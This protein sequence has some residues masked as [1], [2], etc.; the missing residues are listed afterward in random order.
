M[1]ESKY[2]APPHS[3]TSRPSLGFPL[4]TALLLLIIFSLSGIFSCCYHWDK[5]RSLRR[6]FSEGTDLEV[7]GDPSY[8]KSKRAY[9]HWKQNQVSDMPA[10]LM[11]GDEVP[12]FIALPCPCQPPRPEKLVDEVQHPPLSPIKPPDM[13]VAVPS[14]QIRSAF[15]L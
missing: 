6:S 5:V 14:Y 10:V 4:G 15:Y 3:D 1:T 2:Y 12:K 8:L 13:A 11:P 7:G 9:M